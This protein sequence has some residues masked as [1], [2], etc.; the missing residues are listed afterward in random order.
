MQPDTIASNLVLIV[1]EATPYHF[2]VLSSTMHMAWVRYVAERLKS[3]FRYSNQIVYNNFPWPER[4]TPDHRTHRG[5]SHEG[6]R[7][8]F[9]FSEF[10][11]RRPLR[12]DIDAAGAPEGPSGSRPGC[13]PGVL[14]HRS[15]CRCGPSRNAVQ[16]LPEIHEPAARFSPREA[17]EGEKQAR[18]MTI[19]FAIRLLSAALAAVGKNMS[20]ECV[21]VIC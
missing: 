2:G 21:T 14:E 9:R 10:I 16:A 7:Y 6:P 8:A 5:C 4:P 12:S 20:T 3:D 19:S 18:R 15:A 13:R 11:A 17:A 1:P